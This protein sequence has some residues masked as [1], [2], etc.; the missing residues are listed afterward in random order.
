[1]KELLALLSGLQGK[2][3]SDIDRSLERIDRVID[4]GPYNPKE[5]GSHS[6]PVTAEQLYVNTKVS[7]LVSKAEMEQEDYRL[8]ARTDGSR[9]HLNVFFGPVKEYFGIRMSV[10]TFNTSVLVAT[11]LAC[12]FALYFILRYQ[13]SVRG[14]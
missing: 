8:G 6:G 4:G 13:I 7:D 10:L 5:I 9:M 11:I 3:A 1:L 2:S 14:P 12:F